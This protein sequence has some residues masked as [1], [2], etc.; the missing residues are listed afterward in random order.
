[1]DGG[2][3]GHWPKFPKP[4]TLRESVPVTLALSLPTQVLSGFFR[5]YHDQPKV[6]GRIFQ[7]LVDQGRRVC[8]LSFAVTKYSVSPQMSPG[9]SAEMSNR[10]HLQAW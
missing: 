9:A 3:F 4:G 8:G 5:P 6:F 1:M 7:G 2:V 10:W